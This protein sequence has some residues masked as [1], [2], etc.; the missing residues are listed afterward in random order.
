MECT[1]PV[2]AASVSVSVVADV[3]LSHCPAE[4]VSAMA[5][6][7]VGISTV[8][9]GISRLPS[10][11]DDGQRPT[12]CRTRQQERRRRSWSPPPRVFAVCT[13]SSTSLR[14]ATVRLVRAGG[15]EIGELPSPPLRRH[16]ASVLRKKE[17]S[18]SRRKRSARASRRRSVRC[19]RPSQNVEGCGRLGRLNRQVPDNRS[20][21]S[22]LPPK[23]S[24]GSPS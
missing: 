11:G 14:E 5:V 6:R 24:P 8:S 15:A 1:P 3:V 13:F 21:V 12:R 19:V 9:S 18:G 22:P 16:A 2:A 17:S 7:V 20:T 10:D 4:L 23:P